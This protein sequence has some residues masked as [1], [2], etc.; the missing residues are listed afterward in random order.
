M[1][2]SNHSL[3]EECVDLAIFQM[4]CEEWISERAMSAAGLSLS[5]MF[6]LLFKLL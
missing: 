3:L 4:N 2:I 1:I 5:S 6:L